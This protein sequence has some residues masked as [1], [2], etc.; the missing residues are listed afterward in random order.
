MQI[1]AQTCYC[2]LCGKIIKKPEDF[3]LDHSVPLSR[4]GADTPDNWRISHK[5][6]NSKKGALTY[7]EWVLWQE[8]ER[9]RFGH[10][11]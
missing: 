3:N 4:G 5:E 9:K 10:I 8:L 11:R 1:K 6:C 2:Y 7:G